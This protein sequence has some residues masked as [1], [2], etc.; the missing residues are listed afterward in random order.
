MLL[1]ASP[2]G[3]LGSRPS[4]YASFQPIDLL[5]FL[6]IDG[7]KVDA[8]A[9][10]ETLCLVFN[11]DSRLAGTVSVGSTAGIR[12]GDLSSARRTHWRPLRR[13]LLHH[14]AGIDRDSPKAPA[15]QESAS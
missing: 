15:R 1:E 10:A 4:N 13:T 8:N 14:G 11:H 6:R 3:P 7:E 12:L 9:G 2:G 5:F